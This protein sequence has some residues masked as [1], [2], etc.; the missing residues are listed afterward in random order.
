MTQI[1]HKTL[2]SSGGVTFPVTRD[3][4]LGH[5]WS[6]QPEKLKQM[7]NK[8]NARELRSILF[9]KSYKRNVP[10]LFNS[11]SSNLCWLRDFQKLF[12][13]L[14]IFVWD[15]KWQR[16]TSHSAHLFLEGAAL[17]RR[18]VNCAFCCSRLL[19]MDRNLKMNAKPVESEWELITIMLITIVNNYFS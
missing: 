4:D 17:S 19:V 12:C 6:H 8:C 1:L 14:R 5:T 7:E 9:V 10:L 3:W 13:G 18:P 11:R 15:I 2:F 16:N